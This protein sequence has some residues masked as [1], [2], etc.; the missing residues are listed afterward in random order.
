MTRRWRSVGVKIVRALDR[1]DRYLALYVRY[2]LDLFLPIAELPPFPW[3]LLAA[4]TGT[5]LDITLSF[6][7]GTCQYSAS[8]G[9]PDR[10]EGPLP[11]AELEFLQ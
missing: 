2:E 5:K 11:M 4:G 1:H 7:T 6:T 3:I 10:L 8:C 9:L